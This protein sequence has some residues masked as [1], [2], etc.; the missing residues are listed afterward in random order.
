MRLDG[1]N[2]LLV[3]DKPLILYLM[4]TFLE[5]HHVHLLKKPLHHL[6]ELCL[7]ITPWIEHPP[8]LQLQGRWNYVFLRYPFKV[9]VLEQNI[10]VVLDNFCKCT[11]HMFVV[12]LEHVACL[13][14]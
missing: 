5:L 8:S 6:L 3:F 14:V 11:C 2:L 1:I 12:V 7:P 9:N 4:Y 13:N 10:L